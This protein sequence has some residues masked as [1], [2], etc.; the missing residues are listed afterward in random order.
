MAGSPLTEAG[1][2]EALRSVMEPELQKDIVTLNM[3]KDVQVDGLTVNVTVEL[4]TPACPMK[5]KIERDVTSA[6]RNAGAEK[7]NLN[8]TANTRGPAQMRRSDALE[9]FLRGNRF[10]ASRAV[11][12]GLI[13]RAVPVGALDETIAEVLADLR[14][15]GPNALAEAKRLVYDV[16]LLPV[17]EAFA[18]TAARSAAMFAS[19]EAAEGIAAFVGKRPPSWIDGEG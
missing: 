11:E 9:C 14:R 3:V 5:E 1:V 10:T 2:L 7:V 19:A 4:T 18:T 16:P 6:L 15:G 17:D 13:T 12:L 8:M